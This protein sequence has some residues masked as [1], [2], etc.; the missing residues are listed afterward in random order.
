MPKVS[1]IIPT[2]SRPHLLPRTIQ[3]AREAGAD[4]E[5]IVVDDA[6]TDATASVCGSI[7]DI[8][9]VRAERN[10]GVA[11][12][13]NIG[14]LASTADYVAFLDDDDLRLP[15]SLDRQLDL[16]EAMPE[17][18]MACGGLIIG[19][20]DCQPTD[21]TEKPGCPSGDVFWEM[22]ALEFY[23]LPI[24]TVL[25]K[26][27]LLQVGL[28]DR[29]LAGIDDWDRWVRLT[30]LFPVVADDEPVAI[31]R[32]P[33]PVSGQGSSN[34]AR[35]NWRCSRHQLKLLQL[36]RAAAAPEA[37]RR[38]VRHRTLNRLS[39]YLIYSAA[40]WLPYGQGEFARKNLMMALRLNPRRAARPWTMSLLLRSLARTHPSIDAPTA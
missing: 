25:R 17:A 29:T 12:A 39:D 28:F 9:Y 14:L 13:R 34:E 37:Q 2:H 21:H 22:L 7:A 16:L 6:S 33:T 10:Q 31:Y 35:H 15:G 36:P 26:S 1:V 5:V 20:Q 4:V 38:A 30:E 32:Q 11:G 24:T 8:R 19:D 23:I 40:R 18:A 27:R 3:S